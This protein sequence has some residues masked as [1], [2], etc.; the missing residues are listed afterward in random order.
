MNLTKQEKTP[1]TIAIMN[2]HPQDENGNVDESKKGYDFEG[3]ADEFENRLSELDESVVV[4]CSVS[5]EDSDVYDT[6]QNKLIY[7]RLITIN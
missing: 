6:P 2:H 4:M 1:I 5:T 3:M 7:E